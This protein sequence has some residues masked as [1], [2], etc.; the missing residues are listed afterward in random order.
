MFLFICC[1][2][3][4]IH[5]IEMMK[6]MTDNDKVTYYF[7]YV[8]LDQGRDTFVASVIMSV[9]NSLLSV[10]AVSCNT[11]VISVIWRREGLHVPSNPSI[12]CL[13]ISNLVVGLIS[14]AA[15]VI[16]KVVEV[17][18]YFTTVTPVHTTPETVLGTPLWNGSGTAKVRS[19]AL[20]KLSQEPRD[21]RNKH[22]RRALS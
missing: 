5:L 2:T 19:H 17:P 18:G 1:Y 22:G 14:Q 9:L 16:Y 12:Y 3:L 15:F 13:A 4:A 6:K 8:S 10:T 21:I 20:C 11:F 7:L